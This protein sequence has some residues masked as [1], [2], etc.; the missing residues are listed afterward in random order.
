MGISVRRTTVWLVIVVLAIAAAA[1]LGTG[2][3][4]QSEAGAP[5]AAGCDNGAGLADATFTGPVNNPVCVDGNIQEGAPSCAALDVPG[6]LF[7]DRSPSESATDGNVTGTLVGDGLYL[8]ITAGANVN[9]LGAVIKGGNDSNLYTG[10]LQGLHSPLANSGNIPAISHWTICYELED[11]PEPQEIKI[12]KTQV[13]GPETTF[14]F[15]ITC[16]MQVVGTIEIDGSGSK[17]FQVPTDAE[18]CQVVEV[19]ADSPNGLADWATDPANR[20][21]F[22]ELDGSGPVEY[23]FTNT[24]LEKPEDARITVR[25]VFEGPDAWKFGF[26]FACQ[27]EDDIVFFSLGGGESRVFTIGFSELLSLNDLDNGLQ[28]PCV[29][30]EEPLLGDWTVDVDVT[31]ATASDSGS[32]PFGTFVEFS[33]EPG[34]EVVVT[35]TNIPGYAA[36]PPGGEFP[37]P[38]GPNEN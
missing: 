3:G 2:I 32:E 33:I 22:S 17:L 7:L 37:L 8:D 14:T 11:V 34:D 18:Q 19:S 13:G 5:P 27:S 26:V 31:G 28:V 1:V 4:A 10:D 16:D 25:K 36:Q 35:F 9:V 15:E 29:V 12:T 38:D 23:G 20:T 24:Y 21:V 30:A 6:A